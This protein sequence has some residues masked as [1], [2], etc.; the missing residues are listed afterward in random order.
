ML[1]PMTPTTYYNERE[2]VSEDTGRLERSRWRGGRI[3]VRRGK[4]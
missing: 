2:A 4:P 3:R 1:I